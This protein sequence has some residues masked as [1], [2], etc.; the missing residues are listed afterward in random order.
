MAISATNGE[1]GADKDEDASRDEEMTDAAKLAR[2]V[3]RFGRIAPITQDEAE[4]KMA[5][6]RAKFGL[7][8]Q[9]TGEHTIVRNFYSKRQL[10]CN[11]GEGCEALMGV[12]EI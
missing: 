4:E 8:E 2:R 12:R 1:A 9:V 6:R 10:I 7:S 11:V 3:Q 5:K